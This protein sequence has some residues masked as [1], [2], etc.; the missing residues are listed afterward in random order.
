MLSDNNVIAMVAVSDKDA[1]KEFYGN[2]L[3]L[4]QIDENRGGI[5]YQCGQGQ[6][7]VYQTEFA[8]SNKATSATW[9][10]TNIEAVVA[11]LKGR[12]IVFEQYEIPR[13]EIRDGVYYMGP[14]K[15]AWFKDPDGN[16]LGLSSM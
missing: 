15:A 3:G 4:S 1:A 2:K 5:K 11:D 7:F 6:V 10:V 8:G 12:G 9:E 16:T 14:M 13:A